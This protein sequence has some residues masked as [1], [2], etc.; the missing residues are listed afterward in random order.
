MPSSI[1]S[2]GPGVYSREA[3]CGC[4]SEV[5]L[6]P[7]GEMIELHV[8]VCETHM[9]IAFDELELRVHGAKSQLTLELP[10]PEGDRGRD[11]G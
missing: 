9:N 3:E 5:V 6:A 1:G 8:Q 2:A 4:W 11:H 10:S 7:D